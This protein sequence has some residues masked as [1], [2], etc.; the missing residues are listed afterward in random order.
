MSKR[1]LLFALL[2]LFVAGAAWYISQLRAPQTDVGMPP[3]YPEL[4]TQV[5]DVAG[6]EIESRADK[7]VLVNAGEGWAIE[8]R[9]RYPARFEDI[10]R[11]ILRIAELKILEPKTKLPQMYPHIGVE[12]V[13]ADKSASTRVTMK[14][15][16]G[17]TLASL[18][19]GKERPAAGGPIKAARYVRKA[20]AAQ[21]YLV[22]GELEVAADPMAWTDRELL[23]IAATRIREVTIEHPGK[24]ALTIRRDKPEDIDLRLKEIPEGY[25]AKSAATVTSL[26]TAL[27]QLR[28]EDVRAKNTTAWPSDST[29]TTLHGFDGLVAVVRTARIDNRSYSRFEFAFDPA[30]VTA[31]P[32]AETPKEDTPSAAPIGDAPA[33]PEPEKPEVSV[34]DE[35]K[36]LNE[37]VQNWVYVLPEYKQSM[38]MRTMDDLIAKQEAPKPPP[39][40]PV[41]PMKVERFDSQGR[42]LPPDA[43]ATPGAPAPL[44]PAESES[45][46]A[47][48]APSGGPPP[49]DQA[50]AS[51]A[52]PASAE[53]EARHAVDATSGDSEGAEA[54]HQQA[55]P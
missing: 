33:K 18:L 45:P 41:D 19:I 25:K 49:A 14:D 16:S 26:A 13:A 35:V 48:T 17:G 34:T 20:G 39:P 42:L 21:A 6:V 2:T 27:E 44:T 30:G 3:L 51:E 22:E 36:A 38:L 46:P 15:A 7:V 4:G 24:P 32:A 52:G 12:D 55:A 50:T 53:P 29:V 54:A 47:D 5:N 23:N 9:D 28:F 8:N 1:T 40:A 10:K 31:L 43:P 11:T 37:R